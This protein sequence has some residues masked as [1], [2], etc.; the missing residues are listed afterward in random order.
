MR[1]QSAPAR[2]GAAIAR[3]CKRTKVCR[4]VERDC[5]LRHRVVFTILQSGIGRTR[6]SASVRLGS[7]HFARFSSTCGCPSAFHHERIRILANCRC[8]SILHTVRHGHHGSHHGRRAQRHEGQRKSVRQ[9]AGRI[10]D[11]ARQDEPGTRRA[12]PGVS[13]KGRKLARQCT[14]ANQLTRFPRSGRRFPP[15]C[16]TL[17]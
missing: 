6:R 16:R 13:V 1:I 17:R 3:S 4:R 7:S 9:L 15:S 11:V 14:M 2:T 12:R 8:S 10:Q 5:V